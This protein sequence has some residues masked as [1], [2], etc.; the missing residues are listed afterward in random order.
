MTADPTWKGSV[1]DAA[2][3]LAL[4]DWQCEMGVDEAMLDAPVDRYA[5][6]PAAPA[7][8]DAPSSPPPPPAAAPQGE[9]LPARA[10]ALAG[11][12]DTLDALA[13]L[14]ADFEGLDIRRGARNFV[15]ADGNPAARVMVIGEAPGEEEDRQ[16]RPFVGRAGQLLDQM[17]AAI[18]LS[19]TAPDARQALYITNVL[20]WRPPGNRRPEPA[21]IEAML[22][23]LARH[24]ALADP[25][26]VVLMGNTPCQA[27][28]GRQGILRLRGQWTA[29]FGRPAL[30]MTHPAYLLRNP[31]A[32]REAWADLL[33]LAA[34]L[35]DGA[36]P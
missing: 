4:L 7:I 16:A 1:L 31:I 21:E 22:P 25:Q 2:T 13:R 18:G 19:R 12:A 36:Q 20:P 6:T 30:P 28:L 10:A 23:F 17:F 9:G 33:S 32:K 29:A 27:A 24:V 11:G 8:P 35:Q 26:V 15:F 14:Q 3:A 5:E 34:R